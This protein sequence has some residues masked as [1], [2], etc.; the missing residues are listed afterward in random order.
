MGFRARGG[1]HLCIDLAYVQLTGAEQRALLRSVQE[2][3]VAHL[4]KISRTSGLV[5]ISLL[6]EGNGAGDEPPP[7]PEPQDPEPPSPT[8]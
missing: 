4:A 8:N 7:P 3:V 2:T 1:G 6:P 5:T